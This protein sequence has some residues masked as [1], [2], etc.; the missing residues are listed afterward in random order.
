V[1]GGGLIAKP[2]A[3]LRQPGAERPRIYDPDRGIYVEG[4]AAG[5]GTFGVLDLPEARFSVRRVADGEEVPVPNATV[6]V[7]DRRRR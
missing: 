3:V 7:T 1:L 4:P 5:G 2:G 6:G